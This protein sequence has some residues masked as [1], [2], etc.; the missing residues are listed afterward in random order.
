MP[1]F[2]SSATGHAGDRFAADERVS[3]KLSTQ[4]PAPTCCLVDGDPTATIADTLSIRAV[5]RH[6]VRQTPA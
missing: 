2:L 3:S 4:S 1:D 6:G 5:W